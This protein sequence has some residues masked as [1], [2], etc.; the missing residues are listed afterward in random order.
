MLKSAYELALEKTGGTAETKL[1]AEQKLELSRLDTEYRARI[2][3][4]EFLHG[5]R[6]QEARVSEEPEKVERIGEEWKAEKARLE[7]ERDEAKNRVR[8]GAGRP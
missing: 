7:R 4:G 6:V 5:R 8:N 1:T 3:E 2:Q